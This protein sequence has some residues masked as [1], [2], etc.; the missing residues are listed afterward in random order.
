M[1]L[2]FAFIGLGFSGIAL[3]LVSGDKYW[4]W[5]KSNPVVPTGIVFG[6]IPAA[7]LSFLTAFLFFFEASLTVETRQTLFIYAAWPLILLAIILT[8][9]Q[10]RWLKPKWLR[11]LEDHH[12]SIL[13]LLWEE[14]HKEDYQK[15]RLHVESQEGLE[16]WVENVKR[17]HNII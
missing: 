8:I 6:A 2:L 15:W 1:A 16:K 11:W 17:K 12:K 14:A 7:I 10:P 4:W 3:L 13:P 9:W 5:Q